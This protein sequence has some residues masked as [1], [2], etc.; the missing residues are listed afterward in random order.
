[1]K[2]YKND[3]YRIDRENLI[4]TLS[5]WDSYLKK[6]VHLI[7][8]GGTALTLMTIKESTKDIDLII[9]EESEY[10]YLV[11]KLT[12]LGYKQVTQYG[13]KKD[14]GF[15][16]DLYPGNYIYTTGLLESP[17]K[18]RNN[19]KYKEFSSIYLG[20]LNIYDLIISKIFRYTS[21]DMEDCKALFK[22]KYKEI[23]IEKLKK[24]F[25]ETSSYDIS[26]DKNKK[27]FKHFLKTLN[28]EGFKT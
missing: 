11:R 27:N 8:C 26:D 7:A 1:M 13:W 19:L 12:D 20:I 17:L 9:P 10:K 18:N 15:I 23:N 5:I 16:F 2:M 28:K 14:K 24:R 22:A 4:N 6:K 21:V 25:F 3:E